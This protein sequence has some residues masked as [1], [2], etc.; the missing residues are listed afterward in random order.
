M[1]TIL[2]GTLWLLCAIATQITI[3][4]ND[5]KSDILAPH[6]EDW[7]LYDVRNWMRWLWEFVI[8][9]L[10]LWWALLLVKVIGYNRIVDTWQWLKK[11][12]TQQKGKQNE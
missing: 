6:M 9:Y 8:C 11:L 4:V 7:K 5:Y 3:Y 2:I 12:T 1:I 10:P